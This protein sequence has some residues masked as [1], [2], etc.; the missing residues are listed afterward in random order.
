[1]GQN[2]RKS[3]SNV[4]EERSLLQSLMYSCFAPVFRRIVCT[5]IDTELIPCLMWSSVELNAVTEVRQESTLHFGST[6]TQLMKHAPVWLPDQQ[7]NTVADILPF[8]GRKKPSIIVS[9]MA[10]TK[11]PCLRIFGH[12]GTFLAGKCR[13]P[14]TGANLIFCSAQ[15]I[16]GGRDRCHS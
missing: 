6:K 10:T 12:G 15:G 13:C 1:M 3:L 16:T 9:I 7:E 4:S 5:W 8:L 11:I 2:S 14:I